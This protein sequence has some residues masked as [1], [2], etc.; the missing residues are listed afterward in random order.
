MLKLLQNPTAI[1][2]VHGDV[3]AA[4]APFEALLSLDSSLDARSFEETFKSCH[5]ASF[6]SWLLDQ[7]FLSANNSKTIVL[8]IENAD[9]AFTICPF[10]ANGQNVEYLIERCSLDDADI[11]LQYLL[12]HLEDGIWDYDVSKK[13]LQRN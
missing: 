12:L 9:V 5:N 11:R 1:V 8:E 10:E 13:I 3:K 2:N 7:E 6:N 4:N